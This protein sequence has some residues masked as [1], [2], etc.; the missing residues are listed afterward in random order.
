MKKFFSVILLIIC[1]LT[2]YYFL[3]NFNAENQL[4]NMNMLKNKQIV[5]WNIKSVTNVDSSCELTGKGIRIA[6]LDTGI[7][8]NHP[9]FGANIKHGFNAINP[10]ALPKDDNGHGTLVA[11]IIAAQNNKFGI[12]G[13]APDAEIYPVKVLDKYG[14]G[15]IKDVLSGI[16][17][18]ISNKIQVINMSF[19]ILNDN[20]LLYSSVMKAINAG[21]IVVASADNSC[22][23][24]V[25]YPASYKGVISVTA[26]NSKYKIDET[27]P[28]GKIDF[29]APGINIIS[30]NN[31]DSYELCKGT[32]FAAPHISGVISLILQHPEK[33]GLKKRSIYSNSDIYNALCS[34]TKHLGKNSVFGEGFV[35]VKFYNNHK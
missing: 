9:D 5:P 25:G 12:I 16:D 35:S 3:N 21:I 18:C 10:T 32:S 17:W 28:R 13:I 33:F 7:D 4:T 2:T 24:K 14:Q 19:S 23:G 22:G 15:S 34:M 11:G 8:F 29:C 20:P 1:C 6:I 26:V 27:D 30:T 31:K